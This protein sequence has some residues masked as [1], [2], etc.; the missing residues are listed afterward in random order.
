MHFPFEKGLAHHQEGTR[1]TN[2]TDPWSDADPAKSLRISTGFGCQGWHRRGEPCTSSI[3]GLRG[4]CRSIS[5]DWTIHYETRTYGAL[6]PGIS[7]LPSIQVDDKTGPDSTIF[8]LSRHADGPVTIVLVRDLLSVTGDLPNH[9]PSNSL[10]CEGRE[11]PEEHPTSETGCIVFG[12]RV[13]TFAAFSNHNNDRPPEVRDVSRLRKPN[14]KD[15]GNGQIEVMVR[16][17]DERRVR[18]CIPVDVLGKRG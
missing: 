8:S 11:G 9:G 5:G 17:Q 2:E 12:A 3:S 4:Q 18:N 13:K 10:K 15:S 16:D 6:P 7:E 14:V 1:A